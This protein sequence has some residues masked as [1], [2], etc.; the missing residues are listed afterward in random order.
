MTTLKIAPS[1]A[2]NM[3]NLYTGRLYSCIKC[4]RG[5]KW[6]SRRRFKN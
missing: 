2:S 1:L 6:Q 3:E 4:S 5:E